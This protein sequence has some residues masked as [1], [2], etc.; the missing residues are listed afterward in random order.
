VGALQPRSD[1]AQSPFGQQKQESQTQ[2][3]WIEN[4][5]RAQLR[6]E[7]ANH[8]EAEPAAVETSKFSGKPTPLSVTSTMNEIAVALTGHVDP[9]RHSAG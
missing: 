1:C 2:R 7:R 8:I 4:R 3:I 6:G 9:V 5:Q